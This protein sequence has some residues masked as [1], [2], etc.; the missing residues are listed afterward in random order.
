M[1]FQALERPRVEG[2]YAPANEIQIAAWFLG[3][4]GRRCLFAWE[5][6]RRLGLA[7]AFVSRAET[8]SGR[9]DRRDARE[10]FIRLP[11]QDG[12]QTGYVVVRHRPARLLCG[13][14]AAIRR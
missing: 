10:R 8:V 13:R 2:K 4:R 12:R 6:Y 11:N 5:H 3:L 1:I 7:D 9:N 14:K